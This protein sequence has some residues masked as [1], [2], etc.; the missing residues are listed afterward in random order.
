MK[1]HFL[2]KT[3]PLAPEA[4]VISGKGYRITLLTSRLIRLEYSEDNRFQDHATQTVW[5]RN[6]PAVPYTLE[7]TADGIEITT[8][9]LK[10]FYDEKPF[11]PRGLLLRLRGGASD[12]LGQWYYGD[13]IR[14]LKGTARTLDEVNGD[15]V[16][17]SPGILSPEGYATLDDS[18]SLILTE[19]GWV[20]PRDTSGTDLYFFGYGRRYL[21]ALRDFYR[22]CGATPMVPRFALGNWWSRY[23]KYTQK[24]YL[25]LMDRFR[26]ENIPLSVAVIDM[27]WHYVNIDPKYGGGWTGF[28]W[29]PEYFPDHVEFLADLHRRG[30]KTTLNLHP[31][32]G[33]RGHEKAYPTIAAHMG[34]DAEHEQPVEFDPTDPKFLQYYYQDVLN[35]LEDEGVDFWWVDWQQGTRTKIPGLDSLWVLNHYGYL[36]SGRSG[37]RPLTFSR[38]AGPGSHRYPIGFSGDTFVTWESLH[39]Q[40][41]FTATASNIGYGWWSHDIGGHMHGYKNDELM[42]RWTQLGAFSP[43]LRLHSSN[44]E[45]NGKEPWRYS[46]EAAHAMGEILRLRHRMVP[47]IYTM[48]YRNHAQGIPLVQPLYYHDPM[49]YRAYNYG[50][51][52]YFGSQLL[53]QPITS[54]QIPGLGLAKEKMLL[55]EGLWYDVFEGRAY[56]GG[57]QLTVYR[58]LDRLPVF[59]KAGGIVPLTDRLD[60]VGANPDQLHIYVYLGNEGSFTLYEDDGETCGYLDGQSATTEMTLKKEGD[61][62]LFTIHPAQ[63]HRELLPEKRQYKLTFLGC[64]GAKPQVLVNGEAAEYTVAKD[65]IELTFLP[66][67]AI[68]EVR[69]PWEIHPDNKVKEAV[70]DLLN[71]AEIE[72]DRKGCIMECVTLREDPMICLSELQALESDPDLFG[73]IAEILTAY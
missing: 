38:Y 63:G 64:P 28:T 73:A 72:F 12:V 42:A 14:D 44:S 3:A 33:I 34:V 53:V 1:Q 11:S 54:P 22:L 68:I 25:E 37:K 41:Y 9:H 13:P 62:A 29:N 31:A 48:A 4:S 36:D 69:L 10:I 39:F 56:R 55:P 57:R 20:A 5:F 35:P 17:L 18:S 27:D 15:N 2:V 45:F 19:D 23:Y 59:A 24:G 21:D 30:M 50:T 7:R 61:K 71:R 46:R 16:K 43:I 6:F 40:P 52:Y 65:G 8:E 58:P 51:E 32:D 26:E 49:N 60:N 47:Y 70:F 67:D 66:T